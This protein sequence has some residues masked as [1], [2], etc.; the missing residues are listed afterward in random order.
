MSATSGACDRMESRL[1]EGTISVELYRERTEGSRPRVFEI[2]PLPTKRGIVAV[3]TGSLNRN[4]LA[5]QFPEYCSDGNTICGTDLRHAKRTMEA[6]VSDL[7]WPPGEDVS[8]G[9]LFDLIEFFASRVATPKNQRWHDFMRHYELEFDERKGRSAF[10]DEINEMLRAGATLFEITDQ[11][12]IERI[13][14]PE[15][16]AA[17][18]DLQPDTGDEE[19]DALIVEARE[20]FRSPKSQDRQSGLEKLWDAFERLKTIEPGKD[21]KAQ[22]AALLRRVD[23]EPLREKI[24]DEMV[25]LTKI[26][27][28]FRIRHH[29]T[30]KHPV[31]RPEGQDYLFSRLATLVIYLL[32]IS[33]RLKAD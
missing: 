23:S 20:L 12:K 7:E 31:P 22:V 11:G 25:A 2:L 4:M 5:H 28:E 17:L 27:N 19:L 30:D 24:D 18:V 33:D 8:D 10:R 13:G 3:L 16:R 26:G 21:K 9:V 1:Q 15:V 32:K 14:T 29:E 6:L